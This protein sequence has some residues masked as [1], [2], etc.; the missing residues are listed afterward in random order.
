MIMANNG[1]FKKP[2]RGQNP[3]NTP[4]II[5]PGN[6]LTP[7]DEKRTYKL[8]TQSGKPV[9]VV[10]V[11]ACRFNNVAICLASNDIADTPKLHA[12][13]HDFHRLW[14]QLASKFG[15]P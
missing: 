7:A 10:E 9:Y 15:Q 2:R 8:T 3:A 14:Q 13:K 5:T 11:P 6:I 4:R 12:L 1:K